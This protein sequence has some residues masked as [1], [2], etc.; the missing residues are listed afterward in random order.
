[1]GG[2]VTRLTGSR[3]LLFNVCT[4]SAVYAAGDL[5]QQRFEGRGRETA[6]W[7]RSGR[8]TSVGAPGRRR[9]ESL[10]VHPA[11]QG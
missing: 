10:L 1:M 11:G 3:L 6:D 7:R 4:S 8:M 2:R 5:I 9:A